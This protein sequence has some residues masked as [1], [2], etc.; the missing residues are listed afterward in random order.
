MN[1]VYGLMEFNW[2]HWSQSGAGG[3]PGL[4]LSDHRNYWSKGY[5]AVMEVFVV[6]FVT[7]TISALTILVTGVWRSG[8][9]STAAV[10]EAFD[11]TV[12]A[13]NVAEKYRNPVILLLD[14]VVGHSGRCLLGMR[15]HVENQEIGPR[16]P[17]RRDLHDVDVRHPA[18]RLIGQPKLARRQ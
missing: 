1:K 15:D 16:K 14:E 4:D 8:L 11:Q 9:T 7:S 6:S 2:Y 3:V 13:F 12:K 5:A 17:S 18:H 10:A